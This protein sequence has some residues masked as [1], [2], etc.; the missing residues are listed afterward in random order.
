MLNAGGLRVA[1]LVANRRHLKTQRA[2]ASIRTA[3]NPTTASLSWPA[4]S[5]AVVI[6]LNAVSTMWSRPTATTQRHRPQR[7][8]RGGGKLTET[9]ITHAAQSDVQTRQPCGGEALPDTAWTI[10][11]AQGET[12]KKASARSQNP[13]PRTR[14]YIAVAKSQAKHSS[15]TSPSPMRDDPGR[16]HHQVVREATLTSCITRSRSR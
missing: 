9:T 4:S 5:L 13:H 6:R 11:T 3:T 10:E 1:T 16:G 2:T 15:A 8:D 7:R 14:N 12:V